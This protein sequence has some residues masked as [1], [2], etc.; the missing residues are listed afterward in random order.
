MARLVQQSLD[1]TV[2][3]LPIG[4]A[5]AISKT[6]LI[7]I[8]QI[9]QTNLNSYRS[10]VVIDKENPPVRMNAL[11]PAFGQRSQV[12]LMLIEGLSCIWH[13]TSTACARIDP[14][15]CLI[16]V[17]DEEDTTIGCHLHG[18]AIG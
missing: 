4:S 16:G 11:L 12:I 5:N 13:W 1:L 10:R 8:E 7:G 18:P 17:I 2:V 15:R 14:R 6:L 3:D 9:N